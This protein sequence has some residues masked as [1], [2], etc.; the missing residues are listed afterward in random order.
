MKM[1]KIDDLKRQKQNLQ[2]EKNR[3]LEEKKL[4][5]EVKD[6]KVTNFL[7]KL[8]FKAKEIPKEDE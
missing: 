8:G 6:L 3:I 5:K 1:E 4:K 2:Y 7:I